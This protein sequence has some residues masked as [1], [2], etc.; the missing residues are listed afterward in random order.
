MKPGIKPSDLK[1]HSDQAA[2]TA[3]S[4][5]AADRFMT[6]TFDELSPEERVDLFKFIAERL[7]F[8]KSAP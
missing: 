2:A 8:V 7:G 3:R 1:G 4:F 5:Y 6:K